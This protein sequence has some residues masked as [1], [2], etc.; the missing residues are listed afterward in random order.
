MRIYFR[1]PTARPLDRLISSLVG[2]YIHV[3]LQFSSG[4]S[5]SSRGRKGR[6]KGTSFAEIAY[7]HPKRWDEYKVVCQHRLFEAEVYR[8]CRKLVGRD[9]DYAGAIFQAGFNLEGI[10]NKNKL[11]CHEALAIAIYKA[12]IAW[13]MPPIDLRKAVRSPLGLCRELVKKGVIVLA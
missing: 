2:K 13:G 4:I 10:E 1:K 7:S 6:P 8:Q 3:E 11:Y 12:M 9:Y 5:F